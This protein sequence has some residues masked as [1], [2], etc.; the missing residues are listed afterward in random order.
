MD[1][2]PYSHDLAPC[3]FWFFPKLKNAQKGQRF[4]PFS[5]I[6]SNVKT[7]LRGI[8][9]NDFPDCFRQWH[10]RLTKCLASQGEYFEGDS[11]RYCTGKQILLSQGHSGN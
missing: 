5:D 3:D 10:H 11:S 8:P 4:S 9:E 2:P 6:Q 1:H 7:I